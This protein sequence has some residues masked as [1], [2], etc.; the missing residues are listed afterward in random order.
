MAF[1]FDLVTLFP[2]I[3]AP[4]LGGSILGRAA[5]LGLIDVAFT[6]PRDFTD[7]PHRTV[8][9]GPFGGGAGMVMK[10][11][12]LALAIAKVRADRAPQRVVLMSPTG[13][14]F[15]QEVAREYAGLDGL[16][17]VC[18]RYE[19]VD[20]RIADFVVDEELSLGDFVLTGGELAAMAVV[21]AVARLL[22]EVLGHEEGAASESFTDL[23]LLE[24]PQYTRPR[25]WRGHEVPEVLLSGNHAKI[26]AWRL[27]ERIRR[28]AERRPDL[29]ARYLESL[30]PPKSRKRR[31]ASGPKPSAPSSAPTDSDAPTE[32]T[33]Y[34]PPPARADN[35]RDPN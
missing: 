35:S 16:C 34:F 30:P 13:R 14:R 28:T 27:D 17:L 12:P 6:D 8:D 1:R 32:A 29:H 23:P 21:D 24:Y 33:P 26:A 11:E 22:P 15:D 19:G 20:Q 10:P 31:G 4:Y 3:C 2:S 5:K 18:G 7:D 25:D 9:D